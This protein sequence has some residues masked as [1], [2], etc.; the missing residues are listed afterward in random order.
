MPAGELSDGLEFGAGLGHARA[1]FPGAELSIQDW[2]PESSDAR[3]REARRKAARKK[4]RQGRTPV[5]QR[6][7]GR[8]EVRH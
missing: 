5:E 1:G 7:D 4:A 8:T 2:C 3:D 6:P